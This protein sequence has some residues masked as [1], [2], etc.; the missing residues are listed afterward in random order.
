MEPFERF[1]ALFVTGQFELSI[2]YLLGVKD[3]NVHAAP[4]ALVLVEANLLLIT[5]KTQS[6]LCKNLCV[7]SINAQNSTIIV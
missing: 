5:L 2:A 4:L 3:M 1:R 7:N 6:S